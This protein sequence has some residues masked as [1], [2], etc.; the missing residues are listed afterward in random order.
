VRKLGRKNPPEAIRKRTMR[1]WRRRGMKLR[2]IAE[3]ANKRGWTT[4]TGKL[5]TESNVHNVV[6]DLI[7]KNRRNVFI[8]PRSGRLTAIVWK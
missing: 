1:G 2:Q 4:S 5:W 7:C 8:C 3:E 6:G